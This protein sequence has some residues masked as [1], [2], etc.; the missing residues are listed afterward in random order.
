MKISELFCGRADFLSKTDVIQYAKNSKNFDS[1]TEDLTK[2][3]ALLIFSTSKQHTWL[4]LT[5]QRL[6]CV[7]DDI[8]KDQPHIN[9]SIPRSRILEEGDKITLSLAARD[10]TE[11][12]GLLDIG[13]AHPGWLYTKRLFA[14]TPIDQCVRAL[15]KRVMGTSVNV[16]G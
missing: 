3:D 4:T 16:P 13:E 6:Y 12:T 5:P 7:L 1:A 15:L 10:K 14:E 8:R 11:V 9:W 2:S